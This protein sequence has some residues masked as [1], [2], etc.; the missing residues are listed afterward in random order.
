MGGLRVAFPSPLPRQCPG[1]SFMS[2]INSMGRG[3]AARVKDG[4]SAG[5]ITS[6]LSDVLSHGSLIRL[7]LQA[8][9]ADTWME[10]RM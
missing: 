9:K 7:R 10:K 4:L 5:P 1:N 3:S 2:M 8:S 6:Y